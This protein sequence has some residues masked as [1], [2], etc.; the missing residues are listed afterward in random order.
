MTLSGHTVMQI[1]VVMVRRRSSRNT[2]SEGYA[3]NTSVMKMKASQ[4]AAAPQSATNA[5]LP[6]P[7]RT[8][9]QASAAP[10]VS[11]RTA[12]VSRP[13]V[14]RGQCRA[15]GRRSG[16]R[17]SSP[18]SGTSS[19]GR[20]TRRAGLTRLVR[21]TSERYT[22]QNPISRRLR[23][24]PVRVALAVGW[25]RRRQGDAGPCALGCGVAGED[26]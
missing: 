15:R 10:A 11:I 8:A 20:R 25:L 1:A 4:I 22:A 18:S 14:R 19:G 21:A 24:R 16:D 23:S 12:P 7:L 6:S 5:W 13:L 2:G 17:R 3:T 9:R 26:A